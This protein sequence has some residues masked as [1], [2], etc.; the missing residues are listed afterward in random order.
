MFICVMKL[1]STF[2][3]CDAVNAWAQPNYQTAVRL[4]NERSEIPWGR[5]VETRKDWG[6]RK[7]S[8]CEDLPVPGKI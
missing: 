2:L 8:D 7:F 1:L 4:V 5:P 3:L 6:P